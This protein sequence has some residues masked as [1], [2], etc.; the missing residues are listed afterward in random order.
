M[1]YRK[2]LK[3]LTSATKVITELVVEDKEMMKTL[4]PLFQ[5]LGKEIDIEKKSV[6]VQKVIES[7]E[8]NSDNFNSEAFL[9]DM[10]K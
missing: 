2:R 1:I 4:S 8:G 10:R 7:L 3:E 5:L 6:E 9:K